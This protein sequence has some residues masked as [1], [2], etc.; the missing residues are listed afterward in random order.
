MP[1]QVIHRTLVVRMLSVRCNGPL[2]E[3]VAQRART[4]TTLSRLSLIEFFT[5]HKSCFGAHV[6]RPGAGRRETARTVLMYSSVEIGVRAMMRRAETRQVIVYLCPPWPVPDPLVPRAND[7]D[8]NRVFP[9]LL[10][11]FT[12][13]C[14][15][16]C[17]RCCR[18]A[19][20]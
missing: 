17:R 18:I 12:C 9:R 10:T 8:E 1:R 20:R 15:C 7:A 19:P 3:A 2:G 14:C 5:V 16:C 13:C 11:V 4:T 6:A